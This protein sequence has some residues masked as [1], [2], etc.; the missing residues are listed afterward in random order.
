[1]TTNWAGEREFMPTLKRRGRRPGD[2]T[3]FITHNIDEALIL[4][5]RIVVMSA[6][7]GRRRR[8]AAAVNLAL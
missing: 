4:A 6:R 5:D 3:P 2:T 1:M 8:D 7:P